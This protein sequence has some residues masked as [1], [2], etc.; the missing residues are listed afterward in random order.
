ME[1][2][3]AHPTDWR[4]RLKD[5]LQRDKKKTTILIVL[6]IAAGI[7]GGRLVVTHSVPE[8]ALATPSAQVSAAGTFG[9]GP[10]N[11]FLVGAR[12]NAEEA[13]RSH[14]AQMDRRIERDLFKPNLASFAFVNGAAVHD[15]PNQPAGPGWFG[16]VQ[17]W[18]AMKAQAERQGLIRISVIQTQA[19]A[20]TVQSTMLGPSPTALVNGQVLRQGDWISGFQVKQIATEYVIVSKD[21]VNVT[22]S[23]K[24]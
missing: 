15:V 20:L 6:M 9:A 8:E 16:Q 17:E 19:E 13:R 2:I 24:K 3:S 11:A 14:L 22:L 21:G 5:E 4:R 7:V 18:M 10:T 1:K 23:M 12:V